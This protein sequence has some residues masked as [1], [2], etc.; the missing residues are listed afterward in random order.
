M[1]IDVFDLTVVRRDALQQVGKLRF[2]FRIDASQFF[3][4]FVAFGFRLA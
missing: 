3:G 2:D 4:E 1:T